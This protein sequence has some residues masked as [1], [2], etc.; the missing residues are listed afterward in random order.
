MGS[1]R[2]ACAT[3]RASIIKDKIEKTVLAVWKLSGSAVMSRP[4]EQNKIKQL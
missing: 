4:G 2:A 3:P 1:G